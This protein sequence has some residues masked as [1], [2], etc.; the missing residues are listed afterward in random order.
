MDSIEQQKTPKVEKSAA[1]TDQKKWYMD[2]AKS[3]IQLSI[4]AFLTV[5]ILNSLDDSRQEKRFVRQSIF[6]KRA[7]TLKDFRIS[8]QNY[9]GLAALISSYVSGNVVGRT[10]LLIYDPSF[11]GNPEALKQAR[12]EFNNSRKTLLASLADID[13]WYCSKSKYFRGFDSLKIKV[14]SYEK[15]IAHLNDYVESK[16][17]LEGLIKKRYEGEC[18]WWR[19]ERC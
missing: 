13:L 4:G 1:W 5:F 7:Q 18:C 3:F 12:T 15:T 19:P 11:S 10:P 8:S 14:T 9:H 2:L 17:H 16:I 6:E